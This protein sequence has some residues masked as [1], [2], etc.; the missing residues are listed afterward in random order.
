MN[1]E[2][3]QSG[4]KIISD[5][6]PSVIIE[7]RRSAGLTQV[8]L[9]NLLGTSVRTLESWERGYRKPSKAANT[10]MSLFVNYPESILP[11]LKSQ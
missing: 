8:Q 5:I 7:I 9:A 6:Q 2:I 11:L 10:L 3:Q 1:V 4:Y